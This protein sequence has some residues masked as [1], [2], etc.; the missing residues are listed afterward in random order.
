M[1]TINSFFNRNT[2]KAGIENF[3]NFSLN[4]NEMNSVVGG[5]GPIESAL[6][7]WIDDDEK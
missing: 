4:S 3:S 1:K 2:A 7:Y 5:I 6:L